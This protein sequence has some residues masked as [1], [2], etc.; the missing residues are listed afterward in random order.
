MHQRRERGSAKRVKE[1][2]L[3]VSSRTNFKIEVIK[4][5]TLGKMS[6][7]WSVVGVNFLRETQG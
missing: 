4:N 5:N 6:R 3:M 7:R 2:R 1:S